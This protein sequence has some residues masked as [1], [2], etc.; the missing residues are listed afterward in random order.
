MFSPL[1]PGTH[2]LLKNFMSSN[3]CFTAVPHRAFSIYIIISQ[4]ALLSCNWIRKHTLLPNTLEQNPRICFALW[5]NDKRRGE[6]KC[7]LS[8]RK[9]LSPWETGW[10]M[11]DSPNRRVSSTLSDKSCWICTV[12]AAKVI[13]PPVSP[14]YIIQTAHQIHLKQCHAEK[15]DLNPSGCR[16]RLKLHDGRQILNLG[17]LSDYLWHLFNLENK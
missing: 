9:Q 16:R 7:I 3:Y 8:P 6:G 10:P 2:V 14:G 12:E 1:N 5:G 4:T 15:G 11:H 17:H 13:F